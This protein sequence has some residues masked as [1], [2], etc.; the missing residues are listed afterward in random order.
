MLLQDQPEYSLSEDMKMLKGF[1]FAIL[2]GIMGT[3]TSISAAAYEG[4]GEVLK[5][6]RSTY[7]IFWLPIFGEDRDYCTIAD[8]HFFDGDDVSSDDGHQMDVIDV[9]KKARRIFLNLPNAER[10]GGIVLSMIRDL[11]DCISSFPKYG[12]AGT[13]TPDW[14]HVSPSG[15]S[16][17]FYRNKTYYKQESGKYA[18]LDVL[19]AA[20]RMFGKYSGL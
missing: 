20:E 19:Y 9:I 1:I 3:M 5:I 7:I 18:L 10:A 17:S 14:C 4:T 12:Q 8:S 13:K 15:Q 6:C 16:A 11:E 2:I